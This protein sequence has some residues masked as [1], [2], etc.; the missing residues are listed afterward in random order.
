MSYKKCDTPEDEKFRIKILL[1]RRQGIVLRLDRLVRRAQ[2]EID[3]I[4]KELKFRG[5]T[6]SDADRMLKEIYSVPIGGDR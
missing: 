5:V 3:A 2:P 1:L 4:E 6:K